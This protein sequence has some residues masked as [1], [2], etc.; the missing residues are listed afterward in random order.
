MKQNKFPQVMLCVFIA[1]HK[2][3]LPNQYMKSNL[4]QAMKQNNPY[5]R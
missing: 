2:N 5:V 4:S 3:Y 1:Y